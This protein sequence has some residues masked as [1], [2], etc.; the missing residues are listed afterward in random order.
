MIPGAGFPSGA[1]GEEWSTGRSI[2]PA[3]PRNKAQH[4]GNQKHHQLD[5]LSS[6]FQPA[7]RLRGHL[8]PMK[9]ASRPS[10]AGDP[11]RSLRQVRRVPADRPG[12]T[13]NLCPT[14]TSISERERNV[15]GHIPK[16]FQK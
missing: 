13:K 8:R 3:K 14:A 5:A 15:F 10:M 6:R 12:E 2:F 11:N 9:K 1:N 16:A 7:T 4:E